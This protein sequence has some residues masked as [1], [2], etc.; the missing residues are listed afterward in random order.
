[1]ASAPARKDFSKLAI[2]SVLFLT[3]LTPGP[4]F[5]LEVRTCAVAC[6]AL[7]LGFVVA[8]LATVVAFVVAFATV[9][10]LAAGV[11]FGA[12][13]VVRPIVL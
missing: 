8:F 11:A 9:A 6:G 3:T 4:N 1:M 5:G 2:I 13:V 12:V 10:A 7:A